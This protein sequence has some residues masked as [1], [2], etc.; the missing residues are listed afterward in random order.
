[1]SD[2][3]FP[4]INQTFDIRVERATF[5]F[6]GAS[7]T[8]P[9]V[10]GERWAVVDG[11]RLPLVT[12]GPRETAL[13]RVTSAPTRG[14]LLRRDSGSAEEFTQQQVPPVA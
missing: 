12:N 5:S 2:G 6:A 13:Y 8:L 14:Q 10:Q 4:A 1:V 7:S 9:L 11:S 3:Q